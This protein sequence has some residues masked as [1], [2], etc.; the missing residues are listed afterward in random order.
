MSAPH[1]LVPANAGIQI[2]ERWRRELSLLINESASAPYDLGPG[3]RR[4][5]RLKQALPDFEW[6]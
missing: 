3:V 5:E 2:I 1:P 4:D 6:L